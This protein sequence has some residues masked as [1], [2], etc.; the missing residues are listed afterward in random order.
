MHISGFELANYLDVTSAYVGGSS[1]FRHG[2]VHEKT[3][4]EAMLVHVLA[5]RYEISHSGGSASIEPGEL[6]LVAAD[7][8]VAIRHLHGPQGYLSAQWI[9]FH[10]TLFKHVEVTGLL[11]MPLRVFGSS[12]CELGG[13]IADLIE[14][15]GTE[16][17]DKAGFIDALRRSFRCR[18]LMNRL[19]GIVCSI[20]TFKPECEAL[21]QHSERMAPVLDHI[22]H[23]LAEPVRVEDLARKA[24]MSTS[25]F[26]ALFREQFGHSP[27][28]YV[29]RR[30][31]GEAC[32]L[33]VNTDR[34]TSRKLPI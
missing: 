29:R 5:G 14:L 15:G 4:P 13:I 11:D 28:D 19:I 7:T 17:G 25:H 18:E 10:C 3:I 8:P 32:R 12:A 1:N 21:L 20:S 33:L 2:W 24:C 6:F 31:I 9:H 26:H 22:F 27:M 34:R 30:R 16:H 23:R